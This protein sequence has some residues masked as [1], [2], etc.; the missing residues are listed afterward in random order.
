MRYTLGLSEKYLKNDA[1]TTIYWMDF[2]P[3]Q[4]V[5]QHLSNYALLNDSVDFYELPDVNRVNTVLD[6]EFQEQNDIVAKC[7][8]LDYNNTQDQLQH[9]GTYWIK[10][11]WI[12]KL[13]LL[14]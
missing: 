3:E 1:N 12:L 6:M 2:R 7:K 13:M 4:P 11:H 8:H 9:L 14:Y 10:K 5:Y